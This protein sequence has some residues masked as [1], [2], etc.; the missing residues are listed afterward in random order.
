MILVVL[1]MLLTLLQIIHFANN[2]ISRKGLGV[3]VFS[4]RPL[5]ELYLFYFIII[6]FAVFLGYAAVLD[7][8]GVPLDAEE[9]PSNTIDRAGIILGSLTVW[10]TITVYTLLRTR[11][12]RGSLELPNVR[13][14]L[15]G[16]EEILQ[17]PIFYVISIIASILGIIG[18]YLDFFGD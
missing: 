16:I 2:T 1:I 14:S 17:N 8:Y 6:P 18:F 11:S 13:V 5:K 4:F 7:Y 12:I 10:L 15:G 9:I 3:S